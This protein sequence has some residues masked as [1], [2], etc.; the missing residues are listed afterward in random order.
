[1]ATQFVKLADGTIVEAVV[2]TKAE[3]N[4]V[5]RQPLVKV[6]LEVLTGKN[7]DLVAW[8]MEH[9]EGIESA[10][11][12][13]TIKRVTK[14]ERNKLTKALDELKEKMPLNFVSEH[15]D[16][17]LNSFRWPAVQ[18][19]T[20]EEKVVAARNTLVKLTEGD[21]DV[22]AWVMSNKDAILAAYQAGVEK[23]PVSS[24]ATEALAAYQAKRKAE[25]EAAAAA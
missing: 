8:L 11:E 20:D 24:K 13:G 14:A 21:E 22:A 10:F 25:K 7:A 18:R 16:A 17:V 23:R 12:A 9:Q 1:M 6:A 2:M 3:A 4:N 15:A 5:K 19:M